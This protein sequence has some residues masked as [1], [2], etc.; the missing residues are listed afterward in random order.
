MLRLFTLPSLLVFCALFSD[1]TASVTLLI[2]GHSSDNVYKHQLA[3]L[4]VD[5][6]EDIIEGTQAHL[7]AFTNGV[8]LPVDAKEHHDLLEI[9]KDLDMPT[10]VTMLVLTS[11]GTDEMSLDHLSILQRFMTTNKALIV[12]EIG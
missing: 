2:T 11:L 5:S 1:T 4:F 12:I 3:S 6:Y 9:W 10:N 8:S 7:F